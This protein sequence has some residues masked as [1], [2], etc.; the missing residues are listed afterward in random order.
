MKTI[1]S[2]TI[3]PGKLLAERVNGLA[4]MIGLIAGVGS[5]MATGQIIPGI[6]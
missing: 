1:N 4:A 5:Y 2:K 6:F 3:E